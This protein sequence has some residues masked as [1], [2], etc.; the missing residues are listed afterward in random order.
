MTKMAR[1]AS[2]KEPKKKF[3]IKKYVSPVFLAMVAI[4]FVMWYLTKLSHDYTADVPVKVNIDG[5]QFK[6]TCVAK[7]AGYRLV[8]RRTINKSKVTLRFNEVDTTPSVI[9]PG[10]YVISP[11]SLQTAISE[12]NSDIQ[13]ISVGDIP[14]ITYN[15]AMR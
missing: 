1:K 12:R 2:E 14:E 4:S 7:G 13:I 11:S 8:T 6:V 5:N 10:K 9:N 3:N 15:G